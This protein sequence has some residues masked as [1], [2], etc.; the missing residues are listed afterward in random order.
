MTCTLTLII[1]C[2]A[3]CDG[4]N[5]NP[6]STD[7]GPIIDVRTTID[8]GDTAVVDAGSARDAVSDPDEMGFAFT[9]KMVK[10][11]GENPFASLAY[12]C[13][14]CSF[15]QWDSIDPPEGW[16]KGPAQIGLFSASHSAST[17]R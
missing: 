7:S 13:R 3:G 16:T 10:Q 5:E 4:D 8:L 15:A 2:F 1:A 17:L 11:T 14:Q 6:Q 12:E 9:H